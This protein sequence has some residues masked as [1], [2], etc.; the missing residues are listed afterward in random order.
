MNE[1]S[2][3]G[4]GRKM[5]NLCHRHIWESLSFLF[6]RFEPISATQRTNKIRYQKA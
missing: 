6:L 5:R 2:I 1:S 4:K 3:S